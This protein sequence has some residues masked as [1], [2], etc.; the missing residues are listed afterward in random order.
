[1]CEAVRRL[2]EN[3]GCRG[4]YGG[5]WLVTVGAERAASYLF[6]GKVGL[7]T[8]RSVRWALDDCGTASGLSAAH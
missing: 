7:P 4:G 5:V 2:A 3:K 1:M 8:S 6:D